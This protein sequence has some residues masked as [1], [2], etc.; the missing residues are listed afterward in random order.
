MLLAGSV[1][2]LFSVR[3]AGAADR[4]VVEPG[5]PGVTP[6]GNYETWATAATNILQAVSR[7][8]NLETIW[9]SNGH[10]RLTSQVSLTK[11]LKIRGFTGNPAD[12]IF[13][14]DY[15]ARRQRCFYVHHGSALLTGL[16][17]TNGYPLASSYQG[18]GGGVF[19]DA[20]RVV[21]NCVIT[22][23]KVDLIGGGIYMGDGG[24][25]ADC[26]I[27]GNSC[28]SNTSSSSQSGAGVDI[29][30]YEFYVPRG[31]AIAVY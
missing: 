18:Y 20:G 22:G 13:D 7:A 12:V 31:T 8:V 29:G 9:V 10:H 1:G 21:S 17:I 27:R 28:A 26:V 30:C 15:P 19:L 5:T 11:S 16:T 3:L 25:I 23:N 4:Y 14:G 2:L 24:T 6:D